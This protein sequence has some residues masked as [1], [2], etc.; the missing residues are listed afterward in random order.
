MVKWKQITNIEKQKKKKKSL[1]FPR[2]FYS[3]IYMEFY[4]NQKKKKRNNRGMMLGNFCL[5]LSQK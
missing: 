4:F 1:P 3:S 2:H 5:V